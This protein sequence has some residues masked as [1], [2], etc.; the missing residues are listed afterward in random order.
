MRTLV[1]VNGA[2]AEGGWVWDNY[3]EKMHTYTALELEMH[4]RASGFKNVSTI[5]KKENHF[6][7]VIAY[8]S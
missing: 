7:C 1:I 2:D 3:I 6:L 8:K 4:L 5:R